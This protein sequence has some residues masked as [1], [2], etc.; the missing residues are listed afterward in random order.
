MGPAKL[1]GPSLNRSTHGV[2]MIM[3]RVVQSWKVIVSNIL[4]LSFF[5]ML[6]ACMPIRENSQTSLEAGMNPSGKTLTAWFASEGI[7]DDEERTVMEMRY[8]VEYMGGPERKDSARAAA[9]WAEYNL[10]TLT[11]S[12]PAPLSIKPILAL[13]NLRI[14]DIQGSSLTQAQVDELLPQLTKLRTFVPSN[15]IKCPELPRFT[16]IKDIKPKDAK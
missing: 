3:K 6:K 12:G 15:D 10:D 4:L 14:L 7:T 11:L 2:F 1:V 5:L 13:K 16:C 8:A 9:V